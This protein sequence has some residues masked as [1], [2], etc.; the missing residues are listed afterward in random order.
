MTRLAAQQVV[1]RRVLLVAGACLLLAVFGGDVLRSAS[2]FVSGWTAVKPGEVPKLPLRFEFNL[3]TQAQAAGPAVSSAQRGAAM[4]TGPLPLRMELAMNS[5][6]ATATATEAGAGGEGKSAPATADAP[7]EKP[8]PAPEKALPAPGGVRLD[9]LTRPRDMS[10]PAEESEAFGAKTWVIVPP[11]PPPPPTPPP[12]P[13]RAPPLPFRYLGLLND[14]AGR[15]TYFLIRGAATLSVSVGDKFDGTYSLD[16]A[17]GGALQ[18]T[19]LPLKER[20]S[21]AIGVGP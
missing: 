5:L 2:Q 9:I 19:F 21:L 13:P 18:F 1:R 17:D 14:G 12:E 7:A 4:K 11:P 20:Q 3:V 6:P 16:S 10:A 8:A 15:I